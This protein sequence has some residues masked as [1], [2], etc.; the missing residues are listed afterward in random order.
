REDRPA[1]FPLARGLARR[2]RLRKDVLWLALAP[3]GIALYMLYL[4]LAGGDGLSPFHA[5]DVWG[6]HFAG[7]YL[8]IWDGLRAAFE[9]ARQLLSLQQHHVY[10]AAGGENAFVAAEHNRS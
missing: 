1:D 5:Q 6:R 3:A 10:F 8:G 9:G 7:P 2:Y 4:G